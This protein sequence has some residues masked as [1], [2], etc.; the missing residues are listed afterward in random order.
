MAK[1]YA[2]LVEKGKKTISQVPEKL[3]EQVILILI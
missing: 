1:I 3:R 2:S